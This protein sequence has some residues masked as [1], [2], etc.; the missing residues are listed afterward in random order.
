MGRGGSVCDDVQFCDNRTEGIKL[1][2]P[3]RD[4]TQAEVKNYLNFMDLK[5]LDVKVYGSENGSSASI[6]NLTSAFVDG[7]QKNFSSTISTVFKTGEKIKHSPAVS[8]TRCF[9]CKSLLDY[10][11]S[12]TIYAIEYSRLVSADAQSVSNG[13]SIQLDVEKAVNGD[14]QNLMKKLCHGCRN[15][16][17]GLDEEAVIEFIL[18]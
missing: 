12:P 6:Q 9:F 4:F 18:P 3:V 8:D 15:I 1:I 14:D 13:S 11:D 2:R 16:F 17:S 7:L 10:N 5:S